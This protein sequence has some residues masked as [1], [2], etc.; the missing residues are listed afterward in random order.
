MRAIADLAVPSLA[1]MCTIDLLGEDGAISDTVAAAE[2]EQVVIRLEALRIGRPLDL[3]GGHPVARA[4]RSRAPVV[5]DALLDAHTLDQI[6][7]EPEARAFF[8][9][10]DHDS[11]VALPLVA[12]GRLLGA[13]SFFYR[14]NGRRYDPELL[15]LMGDLADRAAMALDNANMYA[16]RT[17]LARTLQRSLLP[18]RLPALDNLAL[19]SAYHPVGEESE[20]GGDFYDVFTTP[21]GCWLVVGD[22]CGKGPEAAAVTALVRHSIRAFAFVRSSPAQV[23]GAVNEVML[24]HALSQ[25]FATAVVARMD[26]KSTP[27]RAVIAGAG[28][29]P[30][31][32]LAADGSVG[33]PAVRGMMLGV[34]PGS[35]V[36]D[37]RLELQQGSTLVLY[38]DGLLDAGAPRRALTPSELC[39][40]LVD[41]VGCAPQSLVQKLER[42]ALSSGAGRLRDDV[43]IVAARVGS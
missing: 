39:G 10:S 36:L 20:V 19:S 37:L 15:A 1:D 6:A 38:T 41:H 17:Q 26:L 7:P 8:L 23:L 30:P 29:P 9:W 32:L 31:L 18:E 11:A 43:A 33:C 40:L 21:T 35:N 28:H 16:A 22:V 3:E 25:R 13:L 24:G 27:I 14:R 4:I 42:L 2:R 12:R 5:A 34:R